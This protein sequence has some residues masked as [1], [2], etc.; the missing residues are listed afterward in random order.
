MFL[1]LFNTFWRNTDNT[2]IEGTAEEIIDGKYSTW[3]M[4]RS[5]SLLFVLNAKSMVVCFSLEFM[6]YV[7]KAT[8]I[9]KL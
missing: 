5:N 3:R 1:I 7:E 8:D 2:P 9:P 6:L 4:V